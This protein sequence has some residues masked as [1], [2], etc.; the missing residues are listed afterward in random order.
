M[1]DITSVLTGTKARRAV[2]K[3]VNAIYNAVKLTLGPE[4]RNAL[5]P[6]SYN[7]GPR[8]TNDGVTV[9]ENIKL[10][11]EHQRLAADFFK[12]GSKKTN[13]MVGDGTTTTAVIGGS[14]V[15]QI[16]DKLSE[17][18]TPSA[19]LVGATV[20]TSG[21]RA[22][23]QEMKEAKEKVVEAVKKEAKPIK[24][25]ED[26]RKI[27]EVSIGKEDVKTSNMIA[28]MVWEIA[29]DKEGNFV[30]NHI[31]VTEGY[32]GEVETEI[33]K[34][35]RFP[36]KVGHRGFVTNPA[37]FEM[38]AEDVP[39]FITNY[40]LDN[41]HEVVELLNRLACP[42]IALFAPGFS[43]TVI[44]SLAASAK[45]GMQCFPILCPALRT[46]QMDDLA[47]FTG[48]TV[49]DKDTTMTIANAGKDKL[50]FAEKITV[51]DVE[52][53]E[54]AVLMGGKGTKYDKV[55]KRIETLKKQLPEA[56]NEMTKMSIERRIANL[57]SAVGVIRV[58]ASTNAELL[59]LKLKIE[60]GVFAC[61]AALQEG[62]VQGGGLCLKEIA[63]KLPPSILTDA[64][65]EPY[66]QIQKNA[67]GAIEI[68]DDILDPAKVVRLEVEHGVMV[69]SS[70]ITTGISVVEL[71]DRA[72]YEGDEMVAKAIGQIA[73]YDAKHKGM[74]KENEDEAEKDRQKEFD[75][76]MFEDHD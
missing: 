13:E 12:E 17:D 41:V 37:R 60:D 67:G 16:F 57:Q 42:K 31:D 61:K 47:A 7:R 18:E 32:K 27:A 45:N 33:T 28:D 52:A 63:E 35:M 75:R 15:N 54:D 23:R 53:R 59:Y 46:E 11:D 64:L 29:R 49:I 66:N 56:Q 48:A 36:A 65:K 5:L 10:K 8:L 58:G 62:Y 14:L 34:G 25:I 4:G 30:D 39:V 9:S 40:K 44:M 3:G 26:L 38:V 76:V 22:M 19:S 6:R 1:N 21:V 55:K 50:G 43:S 51:K 2:R 24:T 69:A 71:R 68:G 74:L 73:Y 72:P 70:L 20:A